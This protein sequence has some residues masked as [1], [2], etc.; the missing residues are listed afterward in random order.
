MVRLPTSEVDFDVVGILQSEAIIWLTEINLRSE[1]MGCRTADFLLSR[2][3]RSPETPPFIGLASIG[4][5]RRKSAFDK[6]RAYLRGDWLCQSKC[7]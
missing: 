1:A 6:S 5:D 4:E 7:A 2:S 3:L